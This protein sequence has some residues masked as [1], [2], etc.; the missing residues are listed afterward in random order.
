MHSMT[1]FI[2][3]LYNQ[4]VF[5][6]IDTDLQIILF[7]PSNNNQPNNYV[8]RFKLIAKMLKLFAT[9][10]SKFILM[11]QQNYFQISI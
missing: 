7:G 10:S 1:S 9:L 11:V 5:L 2:D 6:S 8:V 3:V 4:T